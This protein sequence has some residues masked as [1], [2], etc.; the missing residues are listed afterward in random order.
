MKEFDYDYKN[1]FNGLTA[2]EVNRKS[3]PEL[4]ECHNIEPTG[5]DYKLHELII[6]MNTDD[7]IW[8]NPEVTD[9]DYWTNHP[10]VDGDNFV[11][12]DYD[13]FTNI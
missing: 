6:D 8:G 3:V 9:I 11:P 13:E 5:E 12:D 7:A 1:I 10:A 2:K 4:L